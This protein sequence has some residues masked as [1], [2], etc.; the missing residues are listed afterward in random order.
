M[1]KQ[2]MMQRHQQKRGIPLV[3]NKDIQRQKF[4][5]ASNEFDKNVLQSNGFKLVNCYRNCGVTNWVFINNPLFL[6]K[7]NMKNMQLSFTN[8]LLF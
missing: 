6:F 3:N 7:L 2:P 8:R 5:V 1:R 4:V